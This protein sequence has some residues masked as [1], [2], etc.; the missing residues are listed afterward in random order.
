MLCSITMHRGR[1]VTGSG[2]RALK[3]I[4]DMLKR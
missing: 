2:N 3:S 4:S 1:P